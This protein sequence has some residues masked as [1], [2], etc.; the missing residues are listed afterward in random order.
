MKTITINNVQINE[1]DLIKAGYVKSPEPE[2]KGR[3]KPEFGEEYYYLYDGDVII[4]TWDDHPCDN[5]RFA[6][7]NVFKTKEE[8]MLVNKKVIAKQAIIDKL[9]EIEVGDV[10]DWDDNSKLKYSIKYNCYCGEFLYTSYRYNQM[11]DTELYSTDAKAIKWV[12]DNMQDELKL[13]FGVK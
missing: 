6:V 11:C 13:M 8:A 5:Q 1:A 10:V 2:K 12:I 9:R 4:D 3:W 7:G